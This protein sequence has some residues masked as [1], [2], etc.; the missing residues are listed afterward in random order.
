MWGVVYYRGEVGAVLG[1]SIVSVSGE[2]VTSTNHSPGQQ[3]HLDTTTQTADS[4][5][6]IIF[7]LSLALYIQVDVEIYLQ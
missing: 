3:P 5:Q 7:T 1:P 6:L 4:H 2:G